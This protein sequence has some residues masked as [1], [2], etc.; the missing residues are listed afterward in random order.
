MHKAADGAYNLYAE[1]KNNPGEFM[2]IETNEYGTSIFSS[3]DLCLIKEIPEIVDMGVDSLKIEGRL[4]T[5][6][7]VS[8]CNKCIQKCN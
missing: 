2:P 5:E 6:Y 7:Y 4:K 3:K 1:E 8:K